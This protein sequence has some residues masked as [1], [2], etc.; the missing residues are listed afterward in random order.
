MC[1]SYTDTINIRCFLDLLRHE[2]ISS[3]CKL[4]FTLRSPTTSHLYCFCLS[5]DGILVKCKTGLAEFLLPPFLLFCTQDVTGICC[6]RHLFQENHQ[7][8]STVLPL[9]FFQFCFLCWCWLRYLALY[10]IPCP[11][12][13]FTW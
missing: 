8:N 1:L 10:V 13:A 2:Y 7:K 6:F 5:C 11:M 12:L 4:E 3:W 9:I